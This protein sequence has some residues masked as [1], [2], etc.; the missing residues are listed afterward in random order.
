VRE[1]VGGTAQE[2]WEVQARVSS[3]FGGAEVYELGEV[4]VDGFVAESEER[5]ES[6]RGG[7]VELDG[8]GERGNVLDRCAWV[9]KVGEDVVVPVAALEA[10]F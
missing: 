3:Q 1:D 9:A 4:E 10:D 5:F 7:R 2:L 6:C 8:V